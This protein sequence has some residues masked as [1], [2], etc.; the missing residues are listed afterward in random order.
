MEKLSIVEL[1]EVIEP[2]AM[3]GAAEALA[4]EQPVRGFRVR[5][6]RFDRPE[7]KTIVLRAKTERAATQMAQQ[8]AGRTWRVARIQEIQD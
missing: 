1:T 2:V 3:A 6:I 7:S 5:L 8:R 4:E